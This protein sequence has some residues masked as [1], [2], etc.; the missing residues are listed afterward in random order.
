MICLYFGFGID[1]VMRAYVIYF[2]AKLVWNE[3]ERD[4]VWVRKSEREIL[5]ETDRE[6]EWGRD[7]ETERHE[8]ETH[9]ETERY[10][11]F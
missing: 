5:K 11:N 7:K 6:K 10:R 8:R 2:F 3:R 4:N 9:R 1:I